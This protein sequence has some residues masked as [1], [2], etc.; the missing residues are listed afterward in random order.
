MD[1]DGGRFDDAVGRLLDPDSTDDGGPPRCRTS[2]QGD[3]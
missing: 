1:H 3:R 2:S